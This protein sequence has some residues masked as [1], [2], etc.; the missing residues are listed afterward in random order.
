MSTSTLQIEQEEKWFSYALWLA[1]GT[2]IYNLAEGTISVYF[3]AEDE[4]LT[5]LGFGLDS[6]IETISAAGILSMVL[7][8]RKHG[9]EIG[10]AH[11]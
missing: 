2:I 3:G 9:S 8:L 5:L 10:R 7:R 1:I 11:V 4:A 6:F